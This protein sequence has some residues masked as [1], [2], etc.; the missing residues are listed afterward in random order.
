[1][2]WLT[3]RSLRT[4]IYNLEKLGVVVS[5]QFQSK[6]W[7]QIKWYR[8]D[9]DKLAKI[10][11][12]PHGYAD[13][14]NDIS[15]CQKRHL[16]VSETADD[17][18]L[19]R[20][21][22]ET[23]L[24]PPIPS[25]KK[26]REIEQ[27]YLEEDKPGS[28]PH[29]LA[30]MET[31]TEIEDQPVDL[32]KGNFSGGGAGLPNGDIEIKLEWEAAP[33]QPYPDFVKWRSQ[34]Y[35]DQGGHWAKAA[36]ANA[37]SEI[38]NN[39]NRA[40]DLWEQFLNYADRAADSALA[41]KDNG[42]TPTLPPCF[43]ESQENALVTK[44][45]VTAKLAAVITPTAAIAPSDPTALP[46]ATLTP[47]PNAD[48]VGAYKLFSPEEIE[49]SSIPDSFKAAFSQLVSKQSMAKNQKLRTTPVPIFS[50]QPDL[51]TARESWAIPALRDQIRS[52][53][54]AHPEWDLEVVDGCV[55]AVCF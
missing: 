18:Y 34:H 16:D 22:S 13:V 41:H 47:P 8:L 7:N 51:A 52:E 10:G 19:Q 21:H 27:K 26:E 25:Q 17:H 38:R 50:T 9:Y 46:T 54:A 6:D 35:I 40:A 33:G 1:M 31:K 39:P 49:V 11:W 28:M 29:P 53:I 42:M 30:A 14:K 5:E 4:I 37:R 45:S 55:Q 3:K 44:E 32:K 15:M 2:V 24:S 36:I 23:S 12:N 48:N 43:Q 20:L